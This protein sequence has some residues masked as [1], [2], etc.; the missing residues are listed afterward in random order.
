MSNS[1]A[2]KPMSFADFELTGWEE[3][4]SA[5]DGSWG[6]VTSSFVPAILSSLPGIEGR[7]LIDI[8]TGPGYAA[9]L[10]AQHG[11]DVTGVDFSARMIATA[12]RDVPAATFEVADVEALPFADQAFD[13]AISNFGF[14]H[15]ADP[16][17]A[18]TE[19]ARVLKPGGTLSITVWA[20]S[21]RN[22]AS[23]ILEQAVERFAVQSC[24][25]PTGPSYGFLWDRVQLNR[26][27]REAG[28]DTA[29]TCS[30]LHVIP[31]LLKDADEL[32]RAELSGSVRSGARL[33]QEPPESRE[34]I[35]EAMARE[36]EEVYS[37]NGR[38]VI[39]MAAY[40]I[41]VSKP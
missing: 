38:Y 27:L 23:L 41:C 15:F 4:S 2:A 33:R 34:R 29:T 32:F 6:H 30:T 3:L 12:R 13:L 7:Q 19:I 8:A 20:E 5:Y 17:A 14:Q 1:L 9:R 31:W 35:R 36:I 10:A 16:A 11:A 21:S 26:I 28:F 22:A 25:I 39:P 18:L 24:Q 40:V 37:E